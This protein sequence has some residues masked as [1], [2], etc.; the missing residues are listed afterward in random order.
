[1]K[2]GGLKGIFVFKIY[3]MI[4]II[5][6]GLILLGFVLFSPKALSQTTNKDSILFYT[7]QLVNGIA[8]GDTT[9][10]NSYL[11]DSCLIT[12]E[13]GSVK[14][15]QEFIKGI[16][17]PP[18]Y[19]KVSETIVNPIFKFHINVIV[20]CYTAD[21][22]LEAFGQK[23]LTEICQTDTWIE[24]N[25]HWLLISSAALD[26]PNFP[27]AQKIFAPI[28]NEIAGVYQ[29]NETLGYRVFQDSAKL[30]IQ[31]FG[32]KRNEL[33]C[34]SDYVFYLVGSPLLRYIFIH[35][36]DN[37]IVQLKVRRSGEG[38]IFDKIR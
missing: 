21:L 15:K 19:Y 9:A 30:Y 27:K 1:L 8:V 35:D 11:D 20:F 24:K 7:Q 32:G 16:G 25:N 2:D 23:R 22:L 26:K 13:N 17:V 18:S 12:S 37:K 33:I 10:W 31:R 34:E 5:Y 36:K 4:K 28:I 29:L 3:P 6:S 38:F 14:T